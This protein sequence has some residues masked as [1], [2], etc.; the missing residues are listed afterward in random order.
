MRFRKLSDTSLWMFAAERTIQRSLW[1][2][3]SIPPVR[4]F[5]NRAGVR[6]WQSIS[7]DCA[8]STRAFERGRRLKGKDTREGRYSAS[9]PSPPMSLVKNNC[10]VA[11]DE[12]PCPGNCR[13]DLHQFGN[14][15]FISSEVL[16]CSFAIQCEQSLPQANR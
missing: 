2:C 9:R 11:S 15:D 7:R 14:G 12:K 1:E 5:R 6:P 4:N 16:R 10:F 3:P 8:R 13:P